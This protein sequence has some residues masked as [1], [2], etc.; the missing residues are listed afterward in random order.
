MIFETC[1]AALL[2]FT[3]TFQSYDSNAFKIPALVIGSIREAQPWDIK[4][5]LDCDYMNNFCGTKV[6]LSYLNSPY[7][8]VTT[9]DIEPCKLPH[10]HII[11]NAQTYDFKNFTINNLLIER[12]P[13]RLIDSNN[14]NA[15]NNLIGAVIKNIS[16][17]L[18]KGANR[19]T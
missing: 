2:I 16:P 5:K 1:A 19:D 18:K 12:L 7:D 9:M 17:H 14:I 8:N 6:N 3:V 13:T 15:P 11:G 10:R 4:G